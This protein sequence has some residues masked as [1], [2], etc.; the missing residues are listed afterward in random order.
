MQ[1]AQPGRYEY[2]VEAEILRVFRAHGAERP[3]YGSIVGSGPNATILHHRRNDRR[4]HEGDL[5]L[6]DAGAEYGYYASD[7][8]RTFPVSGQFSGRA[9]R[10]LRHRARAPSARRSTAVRP[11]VTYMAVHDLAVRVLTEGLVEL[12]LIEGPVDEAIELG[13][14]KPYYMHKTSH[15]LGMDVHDVGDYFAD[16]KPRK[17]E[18]GM[19]LTVEPGLYIAGRRRRPT[20]AS[21]ASASGSRTTS[22]SPP[23]ATAT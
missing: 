12:G 6:I 7:V 13:R 22:P 1:V 17:L 16:K 10:G 19:V 3:A 4:M 9:A 21:A 5:L 18:P 15:W 20:S 2:E 14:Y 11:G 8:T 23:T